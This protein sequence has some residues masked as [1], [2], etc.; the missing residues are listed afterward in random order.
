MGTKILVELFNLN[1]PV[2][3]I[4]HAIDVTTVN[5]KGNVLEVIPPIAYS[6]FASDGD[7]TAVIAGAGLT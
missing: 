4:N 2:A 6:T 1:N 3:G 7:I 5:K